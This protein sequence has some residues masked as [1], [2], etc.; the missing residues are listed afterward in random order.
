MMA[1]LAK[2]LAVLLLALAVAVHGQTCAD[3]IDT[4][5]T[6]AGTGWTT[7][8]TGGYNTGSYSYVGGGSN[9]R[10]ATW[11]FA[12]T[13]NVLYEAQLYY[14]TSG[15]SAGTRDTT[16]TAVITGTTPLGSHHREPTSEHGR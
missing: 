4:A 5:A 11:T 8:A 6:L 1:S 3:I 9:T 12:A 15:G 13:A 2:T 16:A 14:T 7:S 10:K